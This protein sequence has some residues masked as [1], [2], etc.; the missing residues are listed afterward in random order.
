[1]PSKFGGIPVDQNQ[2][3]SKFGGVPVSTITAQPFPTDAEAFEKQRKFNRIFSTVGNP[4]LSAITG[5]P[6]PAGEETFDKQRK[7]NRFVGSMVGDIA[8]TA[9]APQFKIAKGI[10]KVAKL[11]KAGGNLLMRS[12]AGGAGSGAGSQIGQELA[13]GAE[14]DEV[15]EDI[16][17][18]LAGEPFTAGLAQTMKAGAKALRGGAAIAK[19]IT[20]LGGVVQEK[21]RKSMMDRTFKRS[22]AFVDALDTGVSPRVASETA[23]N[24]LL[25]K[26]DWK[27]VFKDFRDGVKRIANVNNGEVFLENAQQT[28]GEQIGKFS[29]TG[30]I[31]DKSVSEFTKWMGFTPE[32]TEGRAIKELMLTRGALGPGDTTFLVSK[33][34]KSFKIDLDSVKAFKETLKKDF[35]SD[36]N[37]LSPKT[38]TAKLDADH[39]FGATKELLKK[40]PSIDAFTDPS[41]ISKGTRPLF[42]DRPESVINNFWKNSTPEEMK[43]LKIE[44]QGRGVTK[45][46]PGGTEAFEN[47]KFLWIK[48]L[49]EGAEV[50]SKVSGKTN[51][52]PFKLA[53]DIR[54]N[55]AKIKVMDESGELWKRL[56][57]EAS[58]FE[59]VA[60]EFVKAEKAGELRTVGRQAIGTGLAVTGLATGVVGPATIAVLEGFGAVS[61]WALMSPTTK[62]IVQSTTK[63]F[64]TKPG[65]LIK[66]SAKAGVKAG[67]RF[68]GQE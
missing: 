29:Q 56:E 4:I 9:I 37:L 34:W 16:V 52:L 11:A 3:V 42:V 27:A 54:A 2:Q 36:I 7:F 39:V 53:K 25:A 62:K 32:S 30:L 63:A 19:D 67:L 1:M 24:E 28:M 57:A 51:I 33:I 48:N 5:Q 15:L 35:I 43:T 58:F 64:K 31:E 38:A 23:G 17:L 41:R 65:R 40:N 66:Q 22:K 50:T 20:L 26:Q 13:G 10:P 14:P 18:G 8:L 44:L 45:P 6:F 12:L 59:K 46:T 47:L 60:P 61:A 68:A 55:E 21:I 49:Y